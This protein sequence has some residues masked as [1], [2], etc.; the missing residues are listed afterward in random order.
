[1][2]VVRTDQLERME[3]A[4]E[5]DMRYFR[6]SNNKDVKDFPFFL[7]TPLYPECPFVSLKKTVS[8]D[9]LADIQRVLLAMPADSQ[10][11][12]AGKYVGWLTPLDYSPVEELLIKLKVGQFEN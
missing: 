6:I 8:V 1:M 7:S 9:T 11:A 12:R 4:G 3:A 10:A 5:I 2:G